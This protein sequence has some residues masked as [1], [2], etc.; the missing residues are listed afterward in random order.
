MK[1]KKAERSTPAEPPP[2]EVSTKKES[3]AP[4]APAPGE[5]RPEDDQSVPP[6][7][8][9]PDHV[10]SP[11]FTG[12]QSQK[13]AFG[14]TP[15]DP[16]EACCK[17]QGLK[18]SMFFSPGCALEKMIL[19]WKQSSIKIDACFLPSSNCYMCSI[20]DR[21]SGDKVIIHL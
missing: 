19:V 17:C 6:A 21:L 16:R 18:V 13:E 14:A 8:H 5:V 1:K 20:W 3:P 12:S 11:L 15:P 9:S 2:A 7:Q 4:S 10:P